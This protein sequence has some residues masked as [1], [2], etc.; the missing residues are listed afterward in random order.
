STKSRYASGMLP[1]I[2]SNSNR[3]GTSESGPSHRSLR[4]TIFRHDRRTSDVIFLFDHLVGE[5]SKR[6]G[7]RKA[8]RPGG[9]EID[10]KPVLDWRLRR[11]I[12]RLCAPEDAVDIG[13][14]PPIRFDQLGS[15]A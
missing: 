4:L 2:R 1:E 5:E 3:V 10:A 12:G 13:R 7:H 14:S 15:I 8:E 6:I 11:K 9:L